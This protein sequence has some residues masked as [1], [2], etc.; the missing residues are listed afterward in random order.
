[1]LHHYFGKC[2]FNFTFGRAPRYI[3]GIQAGSTLL[4]IQAPQCILKDV[5]QTSWD[6]LN[7]AIFPEKVYN[8][9][10]F[11]LGEFKCVFRLS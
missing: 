2:L 7:N 10:P 6:N 5:F 11:T 1:M 9:V 3:K 8:T 4:M